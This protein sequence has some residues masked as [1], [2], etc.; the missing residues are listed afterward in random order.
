M[1]FQFLRKTDQH[2]LNGVYT[3][4]LPILESEDLDI[5]L[6]EWTRPYTAVREGM[7]N[8]QLPTFKPEHGRIG[9]VSLEENDGFISAFLNGL[10]QSPLLK[11]VRLP[12]NPRI[13]NDEL[14]EIDGMDMIMM[15]S[16]QSLK[17]ETVR[18]LRR[19]K[20]FQVPIIVLIYQPEMQKSL[21]KKYDKFSDETGVP[22][23]LF[24]DKKLQESQ[25]MLLGA[26]LEVAPSMAVALAANIDAFRPLLIDAIM[27]NSIKFGL[28]SEVSLQDL[29]DELVKQISRAYGVSGYTF[30][31]AEPGLSAMTSTINN[32]SQT[33]IKRFYIRN[34]KRRLRFERA[35]SLMLIG[36]ATTVYHGAQSPSLR[37]IILPKIWRL[38]RES[39]HS[40]SA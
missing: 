26:T 2:N 33:F 24:E 37:K 35:V 10:P 9:V 14:Y 39:R 3:H 7:P 4:D 36:Y 17:R 13:A 23:V 29:Q 31:Q 38:Y 6:V 40:I 20:Y 12:N 32:Y 34:K 18:W 21:Q 5:D 28:T 16:C 27:E 30:K 22:I 1:A 15:L 8:V 25:Q 11:E 19:L